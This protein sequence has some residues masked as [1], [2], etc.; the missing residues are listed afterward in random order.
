VLPPHWIHLSESS[1]HAITGF[2]N[3]CRGVSNRVGFLLYVCDND[4]SQPTDGEAGTH[5]PDVNVFIQRAFNQHQ[6]PGRELQRGI[7]F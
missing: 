1:D 3:T 6:G 5:D 2:T 4:E 7:S